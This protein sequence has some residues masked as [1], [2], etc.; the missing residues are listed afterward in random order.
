VR[1]SGEEEGREKE[2]TKAGTLVREKCE[3]IKIISMGPTFIFARKTTKK[4]WEI[5]HEAQHNPLCCDKGVPVI[6]HSLNQL[7]RAHNQYGGLSFFFSNLIL[8]I[9]K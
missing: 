9:N 4:S 3:A 7:C 8:I 2:R 6:K 1:K 5:C